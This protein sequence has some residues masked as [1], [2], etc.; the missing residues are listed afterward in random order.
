MVVQ[1]KVGDRRS[2][3]GK[4]SS[5]KAQV[6]LAALTAAGSDSTEATA[7]VTGARTTDRVVANPSADLPTGVGFAGARVSAANVVSI[8]VG[9]YTTVAVTFT[10]TWNLEIVRE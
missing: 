5:F 3:S 8:A 4:L 9:N 10:S 1:H 2:P 7:T 6:T